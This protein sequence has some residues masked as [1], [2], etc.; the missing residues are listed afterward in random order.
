MTDAD[1]AQ[2]FQDLLWKLRDAFND[3]RFDHLLEHVNEWQVRAYSG[4]GKWAYAEG[5]FSPRQ[6]DLSDSRL[7]LITS[8][9]HFVEGD[10]PEPFG[11]KNMSQAEAEVRIKDFIRAEPELSSIRVDTPVANLKVRHG[12][13]DTR[14]AQ[15]DPGVAFPIEILRE[16][17]AEGRI[18]ELAL[19]AYAF[20]GAG[21]QR[22]LLKDAGP[23]WAK[24]IQEQQIDAALLVPV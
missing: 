17:E 9:G 7:V 13:Y 12:G 20:V 18:G 19:N 6:H 15:V 3:G 24:M 5:P 14:G 21:S 2:F 22:R 1:A 8:S 11:V 16:L 4:E 23:Q 10:D